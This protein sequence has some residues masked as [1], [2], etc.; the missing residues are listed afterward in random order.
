MNSQLQ[1]AIFTAL[2]GITLGGTSL[3]RAALPFDP[4]QQPLGY[5]P[6]MAVSAVNLFP[7]GGKAY[8]PWFENGA[9]QGDLVELDI[10][11][12]GV[13]GTT[14]DLSTNPP[15]TAANG[16][17]SV[18]IHF[19][20]EYSRDNRYWNNSR[21]VVTGNGNGH[22]IP[23]RWQSLA[24]NQRVALDAQAAGASATDS[25]ILDYVRGDRSSEKP[26]GDLRQRFSVMGDIV[27][28]RPRYVGPP[29]NEFAFDDYLS[30]KRSHQTRAGRIYVGAN[31]GMLHAFA[32]DSGREVFAFI[33]A[34][35][36]PDLRLLAATPY[37]HH[38]YVDGPLEA[39]DA[40][41]HQQ[42]HTVLA[43]GLGAGGKAFFAL[44]VTDPDAGSES[45]AAQKLLWEID[46]NSDD[47]LGY[48]YSIP[49]IVRL[50]D[51]KW[52]A[53][54]GNGYNS[55]N[56]RALLYIIDLE[57]GTVVRKLTTDNSGSPGQPNGL[58]SPTLIDVDQDFKAD[59]AYA[60]DINGNLWKFDLSGKS[61]D[62]WGVSY[63]GT[64]LYS[65]S[66]QHAITAAPDVT[67]HPNGGYLVEF[68]TGR[69]LTADD[70]EDTQRQSIIAVWDRGGVPGSANFL[71]Q[72]FTEHS[73][74]GERVRT[75][76]D[77]QPVWTGP[78]PNTGWQID[79]P[80]GERLLTSPQIHAGRLQ[81]LTTN[82][83]LINSENWL[84]EPDFLSGGPPSDTI[85]DLNKDGAL[86]TSDRVDA[87]GDGDVQDAV[88]IPAAWFR[89]TGYLSQP[90]IVRVSPSIDSQLINRLIL[91]FADTCITGCSGGFQ[92]GPLDV[93]T[94]SR[95]GGT[96]GGQVCGDPGASRRT[97]VQRRNSPGLGGRM[98][99]YQREYDKAHGVVDVDLFGLEP[100]CAQPR[101]DETATNPVQQLNRVTEVS[102]FDQDKPFV[103]LVANADRSPAAELV[104]GN[105]R[106]NAVQYQ[107]M[108]QQQLEL[109]KG[110][111]PLVD[112]QGDSLVF[113]LRGLKNNGGIRIQFDDRAIIDGGIHPSDA[114]CVANRLLIT[115]DRWRNGA[116]T[117]QLVDAGHLDHVVSQNPG[118][119]PATI[120][121]DGSVIALTADTNGDGTTDQIYGGLHLDQES[122]EDDFLYENVAYWGFG[123]L[124]QKVTGNDVPCYGDPQW[125][126]ALQ[127]EQQGISYAE[128]TVLFASEL[129]NLAAEK[130]KL[131][132][133]I[134]QGA[135]QDSISQQRE[136]VNKA[137][138]AVAQG[139]QYVRNISSGND[140]SG[141]GTSSGTPA[142]AA[143]DVISDTP[144]AGANL[145]PYVG[146]RSWTEIQLP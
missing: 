13:P 11:S 52:Y 49:R 99:G 143:G 1:R 10:G 64:P 129:S 90:T 145:A 146:R 56:G 23:F 122:G 2:A 34:T 8:R 66:A 140:A 88:D 144:I 138:R 137:V 75:L 121:I 18:R 118:D 132:Q 46:S 5:A 24:D 60:G 107:K 57:T 120:T 65:G 29:N 69:L 103:V 95:N 54:A 70:K 127:I 44:D 79:L 89:G 63:G 59:F 81:L 82:P 72:A 92:G 105:K 78:S 45:A 106:W 51:G 21:Y 84:I 97:G 28:S 38:Y 117:L 128:F 61:S 108:L 134:D 86:T 50:N 71:S 68:G 9:W 33:P 96:D 109:A 47:D 32:A 139:L 43:G 3:A 25:R 30:F 104:I 27:H 114:M 12:D 36:V 142:L 7:G 124:Y 98:D 112:N 26:V 113:T 141:G 48:T 119:L 123:D 53:V 17:W 22:G 91:P 4:Q 83:F 126:Q 76:T 115:N 85:F 133:L 136:E 74:F 80:V 125:T 42:W 94:D 77:H 6:P 101:P 116:L 87:N 40:Y 55:V 111:A 93:A 135:S 14:V 110:G 16:N 37:Q 102:G 35:V 19:A 100:L 20:A 39:G 41:L 130:L 73:V 131:Q 15:T 67:A 31:D 58:S 62:Q